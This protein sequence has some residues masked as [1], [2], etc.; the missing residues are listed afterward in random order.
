[1]FHAALFVIVKNG[2]RPTA[3]LNKLGNACVMQR[4][5]RGETDPGVVKGL[6]DIALHATKQHVEQY[7]LCNAIYV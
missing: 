1:M 2:D 5:A 7:T 3:Q 6:R 4:T